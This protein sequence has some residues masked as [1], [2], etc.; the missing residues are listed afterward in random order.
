[1]NQQLREVDKAIENMLRAIEAGIITDSTK[2]RLDELEV[3]KRETE[4]ALSLAELKNP[5]LSKEHISYF[6]Y[7]FRDL[8][9]GEVENRQL[10]VDSFINSIYLYDDKIVIAY[11]YNDYT[12]TVSLGEIETQLD[13]IGSDLADLRLPTTQ[14]LAR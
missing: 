10:I 12:D 3:Q 4:D 9:P 6:I 11:N 1:M 7:G 14:S 5:V 13:N 8:D 2:K